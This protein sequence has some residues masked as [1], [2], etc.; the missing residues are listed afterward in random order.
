MCVYLRVYVCV[1][2][3]G[4]GH[5]CTWLGEDVSHTCMHVFALSHN[6]YKCFC[7]SHSCMLP[8]ESGLATV[9]PP[10]TDT[11]QNTDRL[12]TTNKQC[13]PD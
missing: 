8:Q 3:C 6:N 2:V 7:I 4:F 13:A 11:S 1:C 12:H 5:E 9:E 10:I